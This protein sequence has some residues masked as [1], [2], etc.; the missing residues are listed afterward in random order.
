MDDLMQKLGLALG[1]A[2]DTVPSEA[3]PNQAP[4][5]DGFAAGEAQHRSAHAWPV[6]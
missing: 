6:S 5:P 4:A 1:Q 3:T 2:G